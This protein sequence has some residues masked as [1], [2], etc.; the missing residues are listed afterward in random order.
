MVSH[1]WK[2]RGAM[3]L[4][5]DEGKVAGEAGGTNKRFRP[6]IG[7]QPLPLPH[8]PSPRQAPLG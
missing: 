5:V 4:A 3:G 6:L 7:H 2:N 1:G 8:L